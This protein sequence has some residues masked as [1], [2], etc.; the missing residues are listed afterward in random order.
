MMPGTARN[1]PIANHAIRGSSHVLFAKRNF[2]GKDTRVETGSGVKG[3]ELIKKFT[4]EAR[5][6]RSKYTE[7]GRI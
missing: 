1:T 4:L 2:L 6:G 3:L 7:R 5:R